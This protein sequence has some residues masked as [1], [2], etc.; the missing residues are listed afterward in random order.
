MERGKQTT[1]NGD[2]LGHEASPE[3]LIPLLMVMLLYVLASHL[4]SG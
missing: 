2:D 3:S 1:E 4:G